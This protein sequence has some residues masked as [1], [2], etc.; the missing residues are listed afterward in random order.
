MDAVDEV[1]SN[2]I[3]DIGRNSRTVELDRQ[4]AVLEHDFEE[5]EQS[6][7]NCIKSAA[8]RAGWRINGAF[9]PRE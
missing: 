3:M 6:Q 7:R 1:L 5:T 4:I 9:L 2:E 8:I